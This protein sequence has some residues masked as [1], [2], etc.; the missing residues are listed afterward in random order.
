MGEDILSQRFGE[1]VGR[2]VHSVFAYQRAVGEL[3]TKVLEEMMLDNADLC[4]EC[5]GWSRPD[6]QHELDCGAGILL[7]LARRWQS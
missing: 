3:V 4:P 1:V 6:G 5:G 2:G 7:D